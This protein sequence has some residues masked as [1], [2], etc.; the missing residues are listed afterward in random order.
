MSALWRAGDMKLIINA[1]RIK[2]AILA[3]LAICLWSTASPVFC[4]TPG[5]SGEVRVDE[6]RSAPAAPD[7]TPPL[8]PPSAQP[9]QP[10]SKNS[11]SVP[12]P[13]A[14]HDPFSG[15][16]PVY[17]LKSGSRAWSI[18]SGTSLP[19]T[20]LSV[21]TSKTARV[22]E[23]I[24]VALAADLRAGDR[25]VASKGS[26]LEGTITSAAHARNTLRAGLSMHDWLKSDGNIAMLFTQ[27]RASDGQTIFLSAGLQPGS[28]VKR[29]ATRQ[30]ALVVGKNGSVVAKGESGKGKV[31]GY[32]MDAISMV[33]APIPGAIIGGVSGV[34]NPSHT[35]GE[36]G[37]QKSKHKR[38]K[39]LAVGVVDAVPG[40]G[41]ARTLAGHGDE[42][43]L[44]AGDGLL[45]KLNADAFWTP[46]E[47]RA[48]SR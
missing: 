43:Q 24:R 23:P 39:G 46:Q 47:T 9:A 28:A 11:A 45:V 26:I 21:V 33:V 18:S 13:G 36:S 6:V 16:A 10:A 12:A 22:G 15:E 35:L 5:L 4:E 1:E 40:V 44:N 37:A 2:A 20:L 17:L 31:L 32:G 19:V 7:S 25:M 30:I 41:I 8:P 48:E 3:S 42:V 34:V 38:L 27:L 14:S 29:C